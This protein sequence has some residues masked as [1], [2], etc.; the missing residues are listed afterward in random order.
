MPQSSRCAKAMGAIVSAAY[1]FTYID[2]RKTNIFYVRRPNK[3]LYLSV[4]P[5]RCAGFYAEC[6]KQLM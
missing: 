1:I 3:H 2:I 4:I 6:S 5:S